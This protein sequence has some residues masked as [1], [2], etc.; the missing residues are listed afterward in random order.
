MN[1]ER[2]NEHIR[3]GF[4]GTL[5]MRF[6]EAST[7]RVVA[8]LEIRDALRTTT[9]PVHGGVLMALAD[10][11]GAAG[12]IVGLR[13]GQSTATLESKTNFIAG[14][15]D[16]VLRAEARPLHRGRRTQVWE[17]RITDASGRLVAITTQTQMVLE[18]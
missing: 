18:K 12:T 4:G 3:S 11:V 16:G 15:H 14:A 17:T 7:E 8:E 2:L 10:T 5:G 6:V 13:P 1:A 9:G